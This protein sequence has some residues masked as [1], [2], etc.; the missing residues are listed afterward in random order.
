MAKV[1]DSGLEKGELLQNFSLE[2]DKECT[3]NQVTKDNY[4]FFSYFNL[5]GTWFNPTLTPTQDLEILAYME[6]TSYKLVDAKNDG[7]ATDFTVKDGTVSLGNS[8]TS[9]N[10]I[11]GKDINILINGKAKVT[12]TFDLSIKTSDAS[13]NAKLK[14]ATDKEQK[15]SEAL[16]SA[17]QSLTQ[18]SIEF[19]IEGSTL[20][21]LGREGNT[22]LTLENLSVNIEY[23]DVNVVEVKIDN[24]ILPLFVFK[25]QLIKDALTPIEV[26]QK[27]FNYSYKTLDGESFDTNQKATSHLVLV[28]SIEDKKITV[29]YVEGTTELK[30]DEEF[31]INSSFN[32]P[33]TE[34]F[35][36]VE[37]SVLVDDNKKVI[38][39]STDVFDFVVDG[40]VT[41]NVVTSKEIT[42]NL[43]L[44]QNDEA[45]YFVIK[46]T[47][48]EK[49]TDALLK[50]YV[51]P[52]VEVGKTFDGWSL[53]GKTIKDLKLIPIT[54][55]STDATYYAAFSS[56]MIKITFD[57]G[58]GMFGKDSNELETNVAYGDTIKAPETNPQRS[59]YTFDG[60]FEDEDF[61]IQLDLNK[62]VTEEK[63]I[64]AKW[65]VQEGVEFVT[66]IIDLDGGS[67][68]G[69]TENIVI[70]DVAKN[71][72]YP[73][74]RI[75]EEIT[76]ENYELDG[77]FIGELEYNNDVLLTENTTIKVKWRLKTYKIT[78][79][80]GEEKFSED[81]VEHGSK[82]E[83]PAQNPTKDGFKF[84]GW[85]EEEASDAFDFEN[86]II[87]SATNLYAHWIVDLRINEYDFT[88]F[89]ATTN[90]KTEK[91]YD[92]F[93]ISNGQY[94][95]FKE[96]SKKYISLYNG[97]TVT[98]EVDCDG[99]VFM[100]SYQSNNDLRFLTLT[101]SNT[102]YTATKKYTNGSNLNE[103]TEASPFI[104]TFL[105]NEFTLEK[106][107]KGWIVFENLLAGTYTITFG[108][109]KEGDTELG[110]G[111]EKIE[112]MKLF[113]DKEK[114]KF[115]VSFD[116]GYEDAEEIPT[117]KVEENAKATKPTDPQR[118]GYTFDGW[119]E[120]N[121]EVAFDFNSAITE[122]I[123]LTAHWTE[124]T[125]DVKF[126]LYTEAE[127]DVL[128][129]TDKIKLNAKATKPADDPTRA[130]Y[131]FLGWFVSNEENA[132][133]FDF[134][135][136]EIT[137]NTTIYAKWELKTANYVV[138]HFKQNLDG[139][140]PNEP[141]DVDNL[142]ATVGTVKPEVKQYLGFTSPEVVDL[143]VLEDGS[144]VLEYKYARNTYTI[145]FDANGGTGEMADL[146]KIKFEAPLSITNEFTKPEN[147][148][149]A[150][151][152]LSENGD[153][154]ADSVLETF[155]ETLAEAALA[156]GVKL[157]A[158]W[159]D[160]N[161]YTIT[162]NINGEETTSNVFKDEIPTHDAPTKEKDEQYTY[163]FSG[164]ALTQ[165][166]EVLDELPGATEDVT[167]YAIFD[168]TVN[169]Y[170][171]TISSN[172]NE[173]GDID[174]SSGELTLNLPY[175]TTVSVNDNVITINEITYT[176]TKETDTAQYE[177]GFTGW[178]V[179]DDEFDTT[180]ITGELE[181]VANFTRTVKQY[182]VTFIDEDGE[183]VLLAETKY[184]YGTLVSNI[185]LPD[186]PT[187]EATNE[188]IY[189]FDGWTPELANV[190]QDAT[191]KA[192][193]TESTRTYTVT[194]QSNIDGKNI[195]SQ[196]NKTYNSLV[197]EPTVE[198]VSSANGL[199]TTYSVSYFKE[200]TY[201]NAWD[202]ENDKVVADTTIYVKWQVLK[203]ELSFLENVTSAGIFNIPQ[204]GKS[205]PQDGYYKVSDSNGV[206]KFTI[207][208]NG[209]VIFTINGTGNGS[210]KNGIKLTVGQVNRSS[211]DVE[212]DIKVVL[213]EIITLNGETNCEIF[214]TK[215]K[216]L[217][218][219]NVTIKL[220]YDTQSEA[221]V[222][223]YDD[224]TL[225]SSIYYIIG[226]TPVLP[227]TDKA[228]YT[229]N[230]W[231]TDSNFDEENLYTLGAITNE[232]LEDGK[233]SLYGKWTENT[234]HV[235]YV[236][237]NGTENNIIDKNYNQK[238]T[239]PNNPEY[240]GYLFD[241]WYHYV[242][243]ENND[244]YQAN[245]FYYLDN[246][247]YVLD[248]NETATQD[249]KYFKLV[250]WDF[251]NDTIKEDTS[252]YALW[253]LESDESVKTVTF[254]PMNEENN[255]EIKVISGKKVTAPEVTNSNKVFDGWYT[256]NDN[257]TTLSE[258]AYDLTQAITESVVLYAKW[259]NT[260]TITFDA[261]GKATD[262]ESISNVAKIVFDNLPVLVAEHYRFD[263]W[264]LND[265]LVTKDIV[266]N[267]NVTLVA[268]WT[269]LYT[270]TYNTNGH[271][272]Q[273]EVV[274]D[275]LNLPNPLPTLSAKG[276]IFGGWSLSNDNNTQ[277]ATAGE[278]IEKDTILYA[279]WTEN[280]ATT[281]T[282]TFDLNYENAGTPPEAIT[283]LETGNTIT[284]PTAP[285]REDYTFGGWFK[286]ATCE[287]EWAFT[288]EN[289]DTI[290]E[291]N[292]TLY[293]KWLIQSTFTFSSNLPK[294]ASCQNN[295]P[296][297][298]NVTSKDNNTQEDLTI[299]IAN[300]FKS[301]IKY[302]DVYLNIKANNEDEYAE[303]KFTILG[304]GTL[305]ISKFD[306][307]SDKKY[308]N[309]RLYHIENEQ[310]I[311]IYDQR[312]AA[313]SV[314]QSYDL[315][316]SG[317]Y[318]LRI[319]GDTTQSSN[320]K[321]SSLVITDIH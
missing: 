40:K 19:E 253:V 91:T 187:K 43:K 291:N 320:L 44:K 27:Y 302:N 144:S 240:A 83:K 219:N 263:G 22:A 267:E 16:T 6:S 282:V 241:D 25:D 189:T 193:Y 226:E 316:A 18:A 82:L 57:A 231:Y 112:R 66:V 216:G 160:E 321:F 161:V 127:E 128:L 95:Q 107:T 148:K 56:V 167:Y 303:F 211:I 169:N 243:K 234:Y 235:T 207:N 312:I 106:S 38:K 183:T 108:S 158:K 259:L 236:L 294:V 146:T 309:I 59:G 175:G 307:Q 96:Q 285:T 7:F 166:G 129:R 279:I 170:T 310:E 196:T 132:L 130:N 156:G 126:Y 60:W 13:K 217:I 54:D 213:S 208:H 61:S 159:V 262:P 119:F 313:K 220:L 124:I 206:I 297:T 111:E 290:G 69:S 270:V 99:A 110:S 78:F 192:T 145:S 293:A 269:K 292:I 37:L 315:S 155:S 26:G 280:T 218:I 39:E 221:L 203:Y 153:A 319:H 225:L 88:K 308:A 266:L 58:E 100:L 173:F 64:Y 228:G 295:A 121:A 299:Y 265:V 271:G 84:V 177:Y 103:S 311:N 286:E 209:K 75:E 94:S 24:N 98:F 247:E 86:D 147:K 30:K 261:A 287:N 80:N 258:E 68:D 301:E 239:R 210:E 122:N 118:S 214:R 74:A 249:R 33:V 278:A 268:E 233:L 314:D 92:I 248:T 102:N 257:G 45:P 113:Q 223:T 164:W 191:Y 149:F 194:F 120:E 277:V 227:S 17:N 50:D 163:T 168:K 229:F 105:G 195:E 15:V 73:L 152:A 53:D 131:N 125:F 230:G 138:K 305:K 49:I 97:N 281:Y 165:D 89:E 162:W 101:S 306:T 117:Q 254:N 273:P 143:V 10:G 134:D 62:A 186:N 242:A 296:G 47:V 245:K 260:Y 104:Y 289:A 141:T 90:I 264:E 199:T 190:T 205:G 31:T 304:N 140:Y 71:S 283:D 3:L 178:M 215:S 202:F 179:K 1:G 9:N 36:L 200:N 51:E 46:T 133:E 4:K 256:S 238:I 5:D 255:T 300:Y 174:P 250:L 81:E 87:T 237:N 93:V 70:D 8:M 14:I 12:F 137:E 77:W 63:T 21:H 180:T 123:A 275:V 212:K 232:Q 116:L 32:V 274:V 284:A 288:G 181:I 11:F 20:F 197:T 76:K 182:S 176:A 115:D 317:T 85:Y 188:L 41:V 109:D 135:N 2:K 52:D 252:I 65:K 67:F 29:T 28:Q 222:K 157:Y 251:E 184:D 298:G 150:G 34:G 23:S 35:K 55:D 244:T 318:I 201:E 172:N 72:H 185:E 198:T 151:W 79:Y 48:L 246:N 171:V 276:W 142:N 42:I 272:I 154:L 114:T 139:T 136:I 204:D 224:E